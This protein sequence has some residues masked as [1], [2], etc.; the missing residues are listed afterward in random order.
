MA[1]FLPRDIPHKISFEV[2]EEMIQEV[3]WAQE[4]EFLNSKVDNSYL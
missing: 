4:K 1:K 2:I 3:R